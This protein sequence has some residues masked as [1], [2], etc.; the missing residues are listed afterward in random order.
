[1]QF[2][3]YHFIKQFICLNFKLNV[4]RK[5]IIF[6]VKLLSIELQ[7]LNLGFQKY[8]QTIAR[9]SRLQIAKQQQ[10]H[11]FQQD[12]KSIVLKLQV[13]EESN[14]NV[15]IFCMSESLS[16]VDIYQSRGLSSCKTVSKLESVTKA[17]KGALSH[18]TPPSSYINS[19]QVRHAIHEPVSPIDNLLSKFISF[20][21]RQNLIVE[22]LVN[23]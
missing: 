17:S 23:K 2:E 20:I 6:L 18:E 10:S 4:E 14:Q 5:D 3:T 13:L 7:L 8:F 9:K 11:L 21:I 22:Y 12:Y 15:R 16:S 19:S 1:M